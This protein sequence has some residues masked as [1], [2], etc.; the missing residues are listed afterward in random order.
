MTFIF[1]AFIIFISIGF[2]AKKK[3]SFFVGAAITYIF[4]LLFLFMQYKLNFQISS[5]KILLV[6]LTLLGHLLIGEYFDF[7]IKT[8]HYDRL[9]HVFGSFSFSIFLYSVISKIINPID[10]SK[11]YI[12]I[13]V[14]SLGISLGVFIEILE[15][16]LD[17][18]RKKNN[19]K[20]LKDTNF[21]LIY[22][23]IGSILAGIFSF[24]INF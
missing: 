18:T 22:N 14:V 11:I 8:K 10:L 4:Y 9:L 20:G 6:L 23:V 19:Q 13:F 2:L 1:T 12:S 21:D 5:Y 16:I 3:Y 15:Y 24:F 17:S 7:Y